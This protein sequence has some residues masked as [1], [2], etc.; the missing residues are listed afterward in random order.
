MGL[1]D[2]SGGQWEFWDDSQEGLTIVE[3]GTNNSPLS[4]GTGKDTPTLV[5]RP[6]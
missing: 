3:E 2:W 1:Q 6:S 5:D 4:A